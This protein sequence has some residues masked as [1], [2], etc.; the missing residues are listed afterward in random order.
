M[1]EQLDL[2][3]APKRAVLRTVHVVAFGRTT[4]AVADGS[5][6]RRDIVLPSI[7]YPPSMDPCPGCEWR[8]KCI[9]LS[10]LTDEGRPVADK[11]KTATGWR[12]AED[13]YAKK[14]GTP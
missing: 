2:P 11:C 5:D 13:A 12:A 3:C 7:M 9:N 8:A 10:G 14:G 4:V 6:G 1:S